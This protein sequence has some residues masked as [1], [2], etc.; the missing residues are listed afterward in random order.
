VLFPRMPIWDPDR[1]LKRWMPLAKIAISKFGA[2]VWFAVVAAAIFAL[3]PHWS[4]LWAE[5]KNAINIRQSPENLFFLYGVFILIKFIHECGHA[6]A[7]R[8]FG[9]EVHEM[10]IMFLVFV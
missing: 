1:F 10:G 6:F 9:G 5:G 7:C 3:A 4:E 2:I 8:R